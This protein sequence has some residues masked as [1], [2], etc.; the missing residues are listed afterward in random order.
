MTENMTKNMTEENKDH[1]SVDHKGKDDIDALFASEEDFFPM[2]EE[3]NLDKLPDTSS[4]STIKWPENDLVKE[5]DTSPPPDPSSPPDSQEEADGD[6]PILRGEG[7]PDMYVQM[8]NRLKIQYQMLPTLDY[9][10]IYKEIADLSIKSCPTPT[11]QVLNDEIQKVQGAKDRLSEI[12]IEVL[13]CHNFK[14]RAL[15]ILKDSWGKFTTEKNTEAR[16]GDAAFRLSSF[17]SDYALA[18]SLLKAL[19]HVLKNLDSLHDSLS[20]RITIY[21]LTMKLHDV[22]RHAL[23][24]YEFDRSPLPSDPA[25]S[26]TGLFDETEDTEEKEG[27]PKKE[28][29]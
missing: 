21:Q 5:S 19:T 14:K 1:L 22:G 6:I 8:A 10:A 25:E 29:F 2:A 26:I 18:E 15:D 17:T 13:R 27:G 20:R 3:K 11:L 28:S 9:D 4:E 23:P 7:F 12:F 24:D 16:K